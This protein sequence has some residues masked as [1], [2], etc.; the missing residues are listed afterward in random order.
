[1]PG[2]RLGPLWWDDWSRPEYQEPWP[3]D[4]DHEDEEPADEEPEDEADD[5]EDP[6]F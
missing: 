6:T 1:M 5:D 4:D 3:D 2:D